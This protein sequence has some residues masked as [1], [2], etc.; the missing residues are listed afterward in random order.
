MEIKAQSEWGT[1]YE[2]KWVR[3]NEYLSKS[4]YSLTVTLPSRKYIATQALLTVAG[5]ALGLGV[6]WLNGVVLDHIPL[7]NQAIPAIVQDISKIDVHNKVPELFEVFGGLAGLLRSRIS[8]DEDVELKQLVAWPVH[9][10]FSDKK[11]IAIT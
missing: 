9:F 6:G 5:T 10:K 8:L 3:F 1:K 7:V 11:K 2:K 4:T